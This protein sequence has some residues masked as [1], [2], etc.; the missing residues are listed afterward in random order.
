MKKV[1]LKTTLTVMMSGII[2][3]C[4]DKADI[5]PNETTSDDVAVTQQSEN[6]TQENTNTQL[7]IPSKDGSSSVI[8]SADS[9]THGGAELAIV[10]EDN[11]VTF[12]LDSPLYNL[13]GF[14]HHPETETQK[15]R[16]K[17][18]EDIL[19][20]GQGLF[21]LNSEAECS[22]I[23]ESKTVELFEEGHEDHEDHEESHKDVLLQY[24]Y[25]CTVPSS[26]IDVTYLGPAT[27]KQ[28]SMTRK[29]IQMKLS[30]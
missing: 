20:Q 7:G 14:E 18:A 17:M 12:E 6:I 8:R 28:V 2:T 5:P 22:L 25:R 15:A 3:A 29:N 24:Q 4:T 21:V 11:I 10:L 30:R 23:S 16:V 1:V 13:L 27:Q 26:H 19:K 9:H